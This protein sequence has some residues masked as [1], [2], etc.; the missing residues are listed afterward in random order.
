M[1]PQKIFSIKNKNQH[2]FHQKVFFRDE[3][4]KEKEKSISNPKR[5]IT[6]INSLLNDIAATATAAVTTTA[7]VIIHSPERRW[8]HKLARTLSK[9]FWMLENKQSLKDKIWDFF[10]MFVHH[11]CIA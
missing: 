2:E 4:Q 7:T 1:E 10:L 5:K 11:V 8:T 3:V 9:S 6:K